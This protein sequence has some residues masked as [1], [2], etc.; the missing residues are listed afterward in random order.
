MKKIGNGRTTRPVPRTK[1]YENSNQILKFQEQQ[2]LISQLYLKQLQASQ[3]NHNQQQQNN[4][5][6]PP[7]SFLQADFEQLSS[8]KAKLD[9]KLESQIADN[10]TLVKLNMEQTDKI[11][12]QENQLRVLQDQVQ[13]TIKKSSKN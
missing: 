12:E 7:S 1:P 6:I 3:Q 2:K 10:E 9:Q 11:S 8:E 13:N 4:F 5:I